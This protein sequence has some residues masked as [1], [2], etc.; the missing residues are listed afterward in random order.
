MTGIKKNIPKKKVAAEQQEAK[1]DEAT[2][3]S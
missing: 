3:E 1:D 2:V